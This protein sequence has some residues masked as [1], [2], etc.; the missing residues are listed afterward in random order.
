MDDRL[1]QR[2]PYTV[3]VQFRTA[4]SFLVAYSV[5]LSRGGIFL[6]TDHLLE[7]GTEVSLQFAVP[8]AG[9][10]LVSGRVTWARETKSIDGPAGMGVEFDDIGNVLGRVIDRLVAQ[11]AG[12]N[13]LLMSN[14]DQD[15][16]T[17]SRLIKSVI[18]TAEVIGAADA[19]VA[20]AVLAD[21]IDLAI[22]ELDSDQE[23]ALA[24]VRAAKASAARVPVIALAAS[25]ELRERAKSLGADEVSSNPPPSAEFQRVLVRALSKPAA[26][27]N[28]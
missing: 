3:Q 24:T 15:R 18:S 12:V 4:S 28:S 1:H 13:I 9:P 2:I 6:E 8:G 7:S 16:S 10:I 5:N 21:D 19:R 27:K 14:D 11:F 22:V 23:G 17:L 26:V 25:K 20:E